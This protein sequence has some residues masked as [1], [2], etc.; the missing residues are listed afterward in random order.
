MKRA[1]G[2]VDLSE[3]NLGSVDE[4]A[5]L[6]KLAVHRAAAEA[7]NLALEDDSTYPWMPYVW[8]PNS[9]GNGGNAPDDPLTIM[10]T[11]ALNADDADFPEISFSLR[12]ALSSCLDDCRHDGSFA[13][14][15]DLIAR[16]MH[17]FAD[18]ILAAVAAGKRREY[19]EAI[20][21]WITKD[22]PPSP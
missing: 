12:D 5:D 14:S 1:Y 16:S 2:K 4:I 20:G 19:D 21:K 22:S 11:L 8:A 13:D 17:A 9:D 6:M 7:L 3:W 18:E 10:V 15:L